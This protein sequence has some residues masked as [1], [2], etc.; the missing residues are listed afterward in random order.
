MGSDVLASSRQR[1]T[2]KRVLGVGA[3]AVAAGVLGVQTAACAATAPTPADGTANVSATGG[4]LSV[5]SFS[6]GTVTV[7][8]GGVADG[9][10]ASAKWTD[11]TG[12]GAGWS[13]S[14]AV[15]DLTYTGQW[16]Q[17]AGTAT[18]LGTTTA[19]AYT[20]TADGVEY[21]VT[22]TSGGSGTTTPF[23]WTSTDPIDKA[24]GSATATNGAP[25]AVGTQ[26]VKIDFVS[27]TTYPVGAVYR[28]DAGTQS[29]T[30]ITLD[31]SAPGT[32]I[33]PAAGTTSPDPTFV[34]S[35]TTVV[36]GGVGDTHYGTAVKF[37]HAASG[38]GMGTYT[39]SPGV[40]VSTDIGT[41]AATYVAGVQYTISTG[42]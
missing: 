36:G 18:A 4:S 34:G 24:G 5:G 11:K 25:A 31:A 19:W 30:A 40:Q 29:P 32:G 10:L 2:R 22:V 33:T 35:A 28:I 26:G 1:R 20:G 21:T 6:G 14:V 3:A 16:A 12:T 15:S 37:V 17:T 27:G 38:D 9:V 23:T 39:V 8:I 7:P 42:P 13:G 41:W